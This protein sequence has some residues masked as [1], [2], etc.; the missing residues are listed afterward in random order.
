MV[1]LILSFCVLVFSGMALA[2]QGDLMFQH[3]TVAYHTGNT[4]TND[5]VPA[6]GVE[7]EVI[8]RVKVGY[9]YGRNSIPAEY[10]YHKYSHWLQ[11]QYIAYRDPKWDV[12]LMASIANGY[13]TRTSRDDIRESVAI[14]GCYKTD[15]KI[16]ACAHFTPWSDSPIPV[17]SLGFIFKYMIN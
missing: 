1:R 9:F 12:G 10:A 6:I 5:I 4:K 17:K 3:R 7:Y 11:A 15:M 16:H 2:E 13:E 8:D 14:Q